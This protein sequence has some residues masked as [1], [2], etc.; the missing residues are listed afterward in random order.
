MGLFVIPIGFLF[1]SLRRDVSRFL[2]YSPYR[3]TALCGLALTGSY[4]LYGWI[5]GTFD[6]WNMVKVFTFVS[7]PFLLCRISQFR[8]DRR[9]SFPSAQPSLFDALAVA[10]IWLPFNFGYMNHI[11]IWPEGEAAY[12][13]NTP[14]AMAVALINFQSVRR[15]SPLSFRFNLKP[16]H[17][18]SVCICLALF[19]FIALPIG[20]AT[21]FL[22]WN[23]RLELGKVFMAPLGIFFFIAL[24]E[25]LLFRGIIFGLLY[26][27]LRSKGPQSPPFE[28]F[29]PRISLQ[30]PSLPLA[31]VISSLL[32]GF[33]HWHDWG[34]PPWTY[35][36]LA[37]CAGAFYG[38]TYIK[39]GSLAAAALLHTLVDTLW[40]LL[41]HR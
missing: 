13:L 15:L 5:T 27:K 11:W 17:L 34:P 7:L 8:Q 18:K 6:L 1:G 31:L 37:T 24:P 20:F 23:P 39:T 40:E 41:F 12:I 33:S 21:G 4:P 22:G 25:E 28:A 3:N 29:N 38:Y 35:I 2:G 16:P 30:N 26:A 9:G 36:G 19:M 32:F 10:S 14:L